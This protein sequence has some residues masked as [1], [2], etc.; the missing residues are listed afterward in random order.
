MSLEWIHENPPYWDHGKAGI[1]GNA[2]AGIFEFSAYGEGDMLPGEWWRVEEDGSV[3]GYGWMDTTWGDA[4]ILLAVDPGA[5]GKGVGSFIVERLDGEAASRGLNYLYNQVRESHPDPEGI[6]TWLEKRGF[7][8]S[9]DD[10]LLRRSVKPQ[11][12]TP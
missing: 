9:H 6:T 2:P 4:E 5:Q 12:S 7:A 8:M 1:V 3:L 11:G 10:R